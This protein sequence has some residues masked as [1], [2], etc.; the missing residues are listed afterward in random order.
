[1]CGQDECQNMENMKNAN[2]NTREFVGVYFTLLHKV[3]DLV[4]AFSRSCRGNGIPGPG[5]TS[6]YR[7]MVTRGKIA[8]NTTAYFTGETQ[9]LFLSPSTKRP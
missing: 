5:P 7:I 8:V 6:R 1:M 4:T 9:N 2:I 3:E